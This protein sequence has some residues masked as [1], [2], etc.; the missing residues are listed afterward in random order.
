MRILLVEDERRVASFIAR[1][2]RENSY[3][4]DVAETGE[5]ALEMATAVTFD[6]ILLDVRLPGLSG[7]EVC[8]ELRQQGIEA[9]I[10][11]LTAR[12]L[13]EQRVEGLDAGADDYLTKPFALAELLARVRALVRRGFHKGGAKLCYADLEL[14]RHRRRATRGKEAILLTS[15][16]FALLEL[17]LLRAPE[18][19]TRS[20]IIAHIWNYHFDSETNIVEVYINRLRQKIDQNRPA[21]LI[22]TVRGVGYQL[23]MP[24]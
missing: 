1:A 6:A 2:L 22:H 20:E 3:A 7:I 12:T 9:P 13:V 17:F 4:V 15:K 21:K 23:V 14:D 10:L 18:P 19:I 5:K 8:R 16:E 24:E 11:M